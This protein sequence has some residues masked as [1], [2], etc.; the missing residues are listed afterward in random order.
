MTEPRETARGLG[1]AMLDEASRGGLPWPALASA[2]PDLA[3]AVVFLATWIAPEAVRADMARSLMLV[4]LLEF[5]SIHSSAFMG[6]VMFG[7]GNRRGRVTAL[8]GLGGFYTLFVGAF[9][10]MFHTWWPLVSFW[11]LTLNRMTSVLFGQ[12][13]Q[14]EEKAFVQRSRAASCLCYL[15]FCGA[16]VLLPV[17]R[18]GVTPEVV[19]RMHLPGSGLWIDQPWRVLA[20]G[21]LY[22]MG[23]GVSELFGHRWL[24]TPPSEG[25]ASG[26]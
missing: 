5:I 17:P 16:T 24:K 6:S 21:F 22:F 1:E 3:L 8:L 26:R 15:L 13:P 4:M 11:G 20:F 23:V 19:S 10:F 18:L 7:T 14:G 12:A 25:A 2:F 9:A